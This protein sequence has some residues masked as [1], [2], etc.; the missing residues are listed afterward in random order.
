MNF[1][2]LLENLSLVVFF[3]IYM[4]NIMHIYR[5]HILRVQKLDRND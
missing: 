3:S 4:N 5:R 2:A 1:P